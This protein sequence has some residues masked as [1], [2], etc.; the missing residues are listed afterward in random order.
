M[1]ILLFILTFLF[2]W[3]L[4]HGGTRHNDKMDDYWRDTNDD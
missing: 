2:L 1:I 4:T 3:A